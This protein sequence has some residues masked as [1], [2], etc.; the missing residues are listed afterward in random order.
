MFNPTTVVLDAQCLSNAASMAIST[1]A[2]LAEIRVLLHVC[3]A[4][5]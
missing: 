2:G 4:M 5:M 3:P 1:V